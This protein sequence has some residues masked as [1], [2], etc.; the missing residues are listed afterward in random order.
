MVLRRLLTI[1]CILWHRRQPQS[2]EYRELFHLYLQQATAKPSLRLRSPPALYLGVAGHC[3]LHLGQPA[4]TGIQDLMG[5]T[6][7]LGTQLAP[8]GWHHLDANPFCSLLNPKDLRRHHVFQ[9]HRVC[10]V[11]L[12]FVSRRAPAVVQY[13]RLHGVI[14]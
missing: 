10:R 6:L 5:H 7:R 4:T 8:A 3:L 11:H 12:R 1:H 2:R 13:P 14:L 9:V